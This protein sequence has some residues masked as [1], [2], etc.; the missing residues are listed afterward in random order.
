MPSMF[1]RGRTLP[2]YSR[3]MSPQGQATQGVALL[4]QAAPVGMPQFFASHPEMWGNSAPALS[5]MGG[6]ASPGSG[7][8]ITGAPLGMPEFV[9]AN[10]QMWGGQWN[11]F[12]A[13]RNLASLFGGG[14]F[15]RGRAQVPYNA[16]TT[17]PAYLGQM[18]YG[19]GENS[20][21]ALLNGYGGSRR[22]G[23]SYIP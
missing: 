14:M 1:N 15:N 11:S 23:G 12:G 5:R 16:P 13:P 21:A 20:L 3:L 6:Q 17:A 7:L 2:T 9:G 10:P 22:W 4:G 8:P 18:A 19:G